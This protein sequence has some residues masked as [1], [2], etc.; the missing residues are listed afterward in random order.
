MLEIQFFHSSCHT[1][2]PE[3]RWR[4]PQLRPIEL[5]LNANHLSDGLKTTKAQKL[6]LPKQ[7]TILWN[8]RLSFGLFQDIVVNPTENS[9]QTSTF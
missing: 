9:Q 7:I 6:E 1:V 4:P 2:I 8:K 5:E 3:Y